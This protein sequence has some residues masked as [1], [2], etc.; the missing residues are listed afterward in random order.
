[1]IKKYNCIE[2]TISRAKHFSNIA[3]DSLGTFDENEYKKNLL[4]LVKSSLKRIN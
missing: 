3:L 1:M 4:N 2:D